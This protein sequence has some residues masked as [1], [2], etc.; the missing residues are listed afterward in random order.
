MLR[1]SNYKYIVMFSQEYH[2]CPR[3]SYL[4]CDSPVDWTSS[5]L[6]AKPL[7]VKEILALSG[8]QRIV[9]P[10]EGPYN[11]VYGV[12]DERLFALIPYK[13]KI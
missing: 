2:G 8:V 9:G 10:L 1:K 12:E 13:L 5:L 6:R 11:A 7:S 4:S 3:L